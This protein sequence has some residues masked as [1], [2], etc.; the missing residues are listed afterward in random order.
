[1]LED[2]EATTKMQT[3]LTLQY[4]VPLLPTATPIDLDKPIE[5][6]PSVLDMFK[7]VASRVGGTAGG[8]VEQAAGAAGASAGKPWL[9]GEDKSKILSFKDFTHNQY[10]ILNAAAANASA[11]ASNAAQAITGGV[12]KAT[13]AIGGLISGLTGGKNEE[14]TADEAEKE[15]LIENDA[16]LT[17]QDI[18]AAIYKAEHH[19]DVDHSK[20][21]KEPEE[22]EDHR[23]WLMC[24][25][26]VCCI[27]V[28][29]FVL[30]MVIPSF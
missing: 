27:N 25:S 18:E 4:S 30:V 29:V 13:G 8:M 19:S 22:Y 26:F 20:R 9:R 21:P 7:S 15:N 28:F 2:I 24:L 6:G 1:M 16:E 5:P 10:L 17:D 23:P 12:G 11:A 14:K 3:E